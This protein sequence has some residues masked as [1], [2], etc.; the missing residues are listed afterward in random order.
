MMNKNKFQGKTAPCANRGSLR[1]QIYKLIT[2]MTALLICSIPILA[3][4]NA[5]PSAQ[6]DTEPP[7]I[8]YFTIFPSA[9]SLQPVQLNYAAYDYGTQN[10]LEYCSG[11]KKIEFFDKQTEKILETKTGE[12]DD[13]VIEET[14]EYTPTQEGEQTIC[15]KATDYQN[16]QSNEECAQL[17]VIKYAPE[18][19]KIEFFDNHATL[20]SAKKDG[21][22]VSL[23]MFFEDA[24]LIDTELTEINVEKIT[25]TKDDWRRSYKAQDNTIIVPD[26]FTAQDFKC[27]IKTKITDIFGNYAQKEIACDLTIDNKQPIPATLKTDLQDIEGAHIVSKTSTT[28]IIAEFEETGI[29]FERQKNV[30]LDLTSINGNAKQQADTCQKASNKWECYWDIIATAPKGSY[31]ITLLEDSKDDYDN[32]ITQQIKQDID[33]ALGNVEI[34]DLQYAPKFPTE[35]DEISIMVSLNSDVVL[36]KVTIDASQ[37]TKNKQKINAQCY[38]DAD[39]FRCSVKIKNLEASNEPR[40][41]AILVQDAQGNKKEITTKIH[42]FETEPKTKDF[43]SF[44]G[45]II[46]PTNGIDKRTATITEYPIFAVLKWNPKETSK[47]IKIAAQ[48]IQCDQKYLATT[49]EVTGQESKRPT[50][51]FKTTTDVSDILDNSI[52]IPC[53]ANL[54]IKKGN[55]VYKKTEIKNFVLTIPLYNNPLGSVSETIQKKIDETTEQIKSF[56]DKLQEWEEINHAIGKLAGIGQT[57]AQMDA[58]L[59]AAADIAWV[60]A[61]IADAIAPGSGESSWNGFCNPYTYYNI[62]TKVALWSPTYFPTL[63]QQPLK[64]AAFISSCQMCRH[65]GSLVVPFSG[66]IGD[67][68]TTIDGKKGEPTQ[69]DPT[70]LYEWDPKKSIHV[71][72]N[73]Y[74]PNAIEYNLRKEKQLK[75]IYKNCIKE[76]AKKGLLLSNCDQTLKEQTCLYVDSAAWKLAGGAA[77][78]KLIQQMIANLLETLPIGVNGAAWGAVCDPLAGYWGIT[79]GTKWAYWEGCRNLGNG[80]FVL[81]CSTWAGIHELIETEFFAGNQFDWDKYDADIEGHDY[82]AQ[83]E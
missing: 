51:F 13:C 32:Q 72:Q 42:V 4:Q 67:I 55:V 37:I 15:A 80:P 43:F 35:E 45:A 3:Q 22:L 40:D 20:N 14:F 61:V 63:P 2:L 48:T 47:D 74:C 66:A 27:E 59:S 78:A 30:Y 64:L 31:T 76:H 9:T 11:I 62:A 81:A 54:I 49:P 38:T 33:V 75:C 69:I 7:R 73:C 39:A 26:I 46:S 41:V 28:K 44:A 24:S 52:K 12:K 10:N 17:N 19:K 5:I 82:C 6:Q 16:I 1:S 70:L 58:M 77:L 25:G 65:S 8:Q 57:I 36:P 60:I 29:G 21:S 71:A 18:I 79:Y 23:R 34:V 68:T 83:E 56:D 53:T 50:L